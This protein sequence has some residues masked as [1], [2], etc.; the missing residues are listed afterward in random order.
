[1]LENLR[2]AGSIPV[3]VATGERGKDA[4]QAFRREADAGL[5]LKKKGYPYLPNNRQMY[6]LCTGQA[7]REAALATGTWHLCA[8]GFPLADTVDGWDTADTVVAERQQ[9]RASAFVSSGQKPFGCLE[10]P[11]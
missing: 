4:W 3:K 1:M 10:T 8:M 6:N 9:A 5:E 2:C 11:R 7:G